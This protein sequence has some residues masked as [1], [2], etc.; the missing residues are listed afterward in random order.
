VCK[1]RVCDATDGYGTES[2]NSGEL[3]GMY[4]LICPYGALIFISWKGCSRLK[5]FTFFE[6]SISHCMGGDNGY[7]SS[8]K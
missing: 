3:Q 4:V 1:T 6:N 8:A 5:Y 2:N 7:L